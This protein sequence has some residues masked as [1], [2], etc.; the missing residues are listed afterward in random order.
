MIWNS[1]AVKGVLDELHRFGDDT[2]L[3]ECKRAAVAMPESLG[4]TLSA[5]AN[6]PE[7][8]L[9]LLGVDERRGFEAT[10]VKNPAEMVKKVADFSRSAIDPAPQCTASTVDID[11]KSVIVIEVVPLAPALKPARYQGKAYLRQA[12]GDYVMNANDLRMLEISA[13]T[14]R[15]SPEYDFASVPETSVSICDEE[16][17][18]QY[19]SNIRRSQNRLA[20]VD[21][22][23]TLL[24]MTG[25]CDT[26]GNLRLA[27]LYGLGY[28]PQSIEPTLGAT[29]A[30]RIARSSTGQRNKDLENITGPL[31]ALLQDSLDWVHAH[32]SKV[33]IYHRDGNLVDVPEFPL[34]AIREALANAF[35][36]RDLGPSLDVGKKVEIRLTEKSLIIKNPGGLRGLS[37]D[38]IESSTLTK[39]AVNK[40]LYEIARYLN[41][42]DGERVI[43]G[44][45]G[46]IQ[47]ILTSTRMEGCHRPRFIDTGVDFT[48][49]F[50]RGS[51]FTDADEEWF[52]TFNT[53]LDPLAKDLLLGL[54][55]DGEWEWSS[56]LR[57]FA[58]ISPR[59]VERMVNE[60]E[61]A[62]II[63]V[64]D[65]IVFLAGH[66]PKPAIDFARLGKNVPAVLT[67]LRNHPGAT[68][69]DISES[70][71]LSANQARYALKPLV[72]RDLVVMHG[73]VGQ[74]ETT[75]TLRSF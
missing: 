36:H 63:T 59:D 70:T 64:D 29:A 30:V 33:S 4:E 21:E 44:E 74:K 15:E 41:T 50:P 22:Q 26:D 35:V 25:V 19:L 28:Y 62:G 11:G 6:M 23:D 56:I 61:S 58:P 48:V 43:E 67:Y 69:Q 8:G 51:R 27:G 49:I 71:G 2:T 24:Q 75:Y 1:Q 42:S 38:Q 73:G 46:G 39:A 9:I 12:D 10:G 34:S 53:K 57:N 60:L 32:L 13:L 65:D 54:R 66:R 14:E 45:G 52:A 40:R 7:P 72:D 31:P 20:K 16:V 17:L 68:R 18:K 37:T 47:E 55:R 3:V 5:F